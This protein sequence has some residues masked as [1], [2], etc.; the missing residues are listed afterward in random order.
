MPALSGIREAYVVTTRDV[1]ITGITDPV[2]LREADT[3]TSTFS[4]LLGTSMNKRLLKDYQAWPSEWQKF[5]TITPIKDFRLQSRIRLGAFGSL[6][7]VNEDTAYTTI[8]L[9]DTQATYSPGKRGNLVA[10]TRET[11]VND[12]LYAIKQIPGKLAVAA[13]FTLAEFIYALLAANGAAIYDTFKL[14][15][16]IN[17]LNTGIITANLGTPNSGTALSSAN[18]Q[19]AVMKMRRQLNMA[20]KPIGL[21]PR[22]I[23]VPP[24]TGVRGHDGGEV[25]GVPGSNFND[26][27]PMLGY[28][29]VVVAPQI[30]STTYWAAIA[31][32]RVIDTIEVGFVGGQMNPQLFIQDQPLYGNNFTNDVI[33]Y[34]VRH[35]YGGAVVDYRGFYLGNN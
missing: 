20:N 17:H 12:D 25:C 28:A 34:K 7:T 2:R 5:V 26:I 16:S 19:T 27:N 24:R 8:S 15:D 1:G 23:V 30:A 9:S 33:T 29:E 21:K 22:F 14:F 32:P 3:T 31:D 4:Y 10:V 11:I 6:S 13:A 35:E 18:L